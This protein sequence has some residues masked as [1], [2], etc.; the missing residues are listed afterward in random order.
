ML[1]PWLGLIGAVVACGAPTSVPVLT[2]ERIVGDTRGAGMDN[3][4][5]TTTSDGT[6]FLLMRSGRIA[7]FDA[8]GTYVR[9]ET[10]PRPVRWPH[11]DTY[12]TGIGSRVFV[13]EYH[14]DY[15][16]VVD[17]AKGAQPGSFTKP[18][19]V[20]EDARARTYVADRGNR[21]V[22]VFG[23]GD[24]RKP[25]QVLTLS[26]EPVAVA[27]RAGRLAAVTAQGSLHV[28]REA[29]DRMQP[30]G[31][32]KIGPQA[33]DL[34]LT[35]SGDVLVC[36]GGGWDRHDLKRYCVKHGTLRELG[37]IAR[38]FRAQ[39]PQ[40][41]ASPVVLSPGVAGRTILFA[42]TQEGHVLS[43]DVATDKVTELVR[44]VPRPIS[45]AYDGQGRLLVGCQLN[46]H[47]AKGQVVYAYAPGAKVHKQAQTIPQRGHFATALSANMLWGML[48]ARDG[49]VY[50]RVIDGNDWTAFKIKKVYPD[51]KVTNWLDLGSRLYGKVKRFGPSGA[52]YALQ[53][54]SA[55]H[56]IGAFSVLGVV[57]KLSPSGAIQWQAGCVPA[58]G[59]AAIDFGC[60]RDVAHDAR[61][62]IWVVD[63]QRHCLC[64]LDGSGRLVWQYGKKGD[65]DDRDGTHFY[66]PTGV[67]VVRTRDGIQWLYVGDAGN[68]RLIKYRLEYRGER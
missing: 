48:G 16:W 17:G 55:G 33:R 64:C 12:L 53:H 8:H 11:Y 32:W 4:S 61:G 65:V 60:P 43:L 23:P 35:P 30:V 37:V 21:R 22:Q 5:V 54:D 45:A 3:L 39:W 41:F 38:S 31:S 1:T 2:L 47:Q 24:H 42:A 51:G 52:H 10:S 63:S 14:L 9:S 59:G 56:V 49:G 27:V 6:T 28:Y 20:A 36:F 18:A 57:M 29:N 40:V 13:G 26:G 46:K 7:I 50:V 44:H 25:L 15:P 66:R 58:G 62:N 34:C 68:E 19:G 67:E